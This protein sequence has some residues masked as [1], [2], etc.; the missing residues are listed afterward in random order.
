M[1]KTDGRECRRGP[2]VQATV[3]PAM[4]IVHLPTLCNVFRLIDT[5]RPCDNGRA[6]SRL[7]RGIRG[8]MRP[9]TTSSGRAFKKW[10]TFLSKREQM[11]PLERSAPAG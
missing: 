7:V 10:Q 5:D 3:R 9:G 2:V 11:R 1:L 6:P 4:I 8:I